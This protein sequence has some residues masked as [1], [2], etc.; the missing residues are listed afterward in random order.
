LSR[1]GGWAGRLIRRLVEQA[2]HQGEIEPAAELDA[3]LAHVA[4]LP[5]A[6]FLVQ[7]D[8]GDI[9]RLDGADHGV[10]AACPRTGDQR[11]EEGSANPP[12]APAGCD[13]DRMLDRVPATL[14]GFPLS[15]R[16]IAGGGPVIV[17]GEDHRIADLRACLEPGQALGLVDL[18]I[19]PDRG[20]VTDGF[21][22]D[23]GD[24]RNVRPGRVAH[25]HSGLLARLAACYPSRTS[26]GSSSWPLETSP[27]AW[28]TAGSRMSSSSPR[29]SAGRSPM[30]QAAR[31]AGLSGGISSVRG[32]AAIGPMPASRISACMAVS[33]RP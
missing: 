16:G 31:W 23:G 32:S 30:S 21:V 15:V 13:I 14:I 5:E 22:E 20:R 26:A 6:E 28:R 10:H 29:H 12:A 19:E 17:D 7:A 25:F 18:G 2:L 9:L 4:D 3:D 11:L 33:T 24:G 1:R 27:A 8:R